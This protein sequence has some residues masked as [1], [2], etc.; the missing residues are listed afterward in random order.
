MSDALHRFNDELR[1]RVVPLERWLSR[2]PSGLD[3]AYGA[4]LVTREQIDAAEIAGAPMFVIDDDELRNR[5]RVI[6]PASLKT[7][8]ILVIT[9]IYGT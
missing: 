1:E 3:V 2:Q 4:A 5:A 7:G 8:D 9:A 6:L